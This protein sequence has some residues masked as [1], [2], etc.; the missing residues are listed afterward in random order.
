M[1]WLLDQG[2]PLSAASLLQAVGEN[3]IHVAS[4][5]MSKSPDEAILEYA[6]SEG[7]VVV[8]LMLIFMPC[9]HSLEQLLRVWCEFGK[10]DSRHQ[11]QGI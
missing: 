10:R 4:L 1:R 3:A 5:H 6:R 7:R 8:L 9:L 2:L 11:R